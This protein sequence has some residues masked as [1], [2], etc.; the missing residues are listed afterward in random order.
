[1]DESGDERAGNDGGV[2]VYVE[3]AHRPYSYI[4]SAFNKATITVRH[5]KTYS[6]TITFSFSI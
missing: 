3:Q 6:L 2:S 1:M 4:F 5:Y